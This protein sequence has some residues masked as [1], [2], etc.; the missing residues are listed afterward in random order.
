MIIRFLYN[1]PARWY[2]VN[3]KTVG[4]IVRRSG[5]GAASIFEGYEIAGGVIVGRMLV[6]VFGR[7]GLIG[8]G[9]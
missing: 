9:A 4:V 1:I 3:I 8:G 5:A 2:F 7:G 6:G